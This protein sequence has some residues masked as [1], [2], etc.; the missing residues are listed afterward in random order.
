MKPKRWW[1][2]KFACMRS[3]SGNLKKDVYGSDKGY[4]F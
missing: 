2:A 4:N 1:K 3:I